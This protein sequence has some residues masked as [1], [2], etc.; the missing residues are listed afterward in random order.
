MH[1]QQG[2]MYNPWLGG[3]Q[4]IDGGM[5]PGVAIKYT[6]WGITTPSNRR[7]KVARLMGSVDG[8]YDP[9]LLSS[10]RCIRW[11]RLNH[12]YSMFLS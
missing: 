5:L 8:I 6:D 10:S 9:A 11:F 7:K 1:Q 2:L 12:D 3:Y 4:T